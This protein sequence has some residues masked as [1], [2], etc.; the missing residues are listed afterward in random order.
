MFDKIVKEVVRWDM[1]TTE[2]R[3]SYCLGWYIAAEWWGGR[4]NL[5][6]GHRAVLNGVEGPIP[7]RGWG[8]ASDSNRAWSVLS[9]PH[10]TKPASLFATKNPYPW[11]PTTQ[12]FAF[13]KRT[14]PQRPMPA[15]QSCLF[16]PAQLIQIPPLTWVGPITRWT[17]FIKKMRQ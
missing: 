13:R 14:Q 17:D 10:C 6:G 11:P 16:Q 2:S 7:Q 1:Q 15:Y 8:L 12:P 3:W 9:F 5:A 4:E